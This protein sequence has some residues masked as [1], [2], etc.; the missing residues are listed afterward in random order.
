MNDIEK[1]FYHNQNRDLKKYP[2]YL[3]IY[4]KYFS[5][6]R[7][8]NIN[9][10]EIGV[11]YGG[12]L[13]MWKAYFGDNVK[14]YG[15]DHNDCSRM[16][17]EQIE[18]FIGSQS[19]RKFLK[20]FCEKIKKIDILIDDGSH[21][22]SDQITTFEELF[23]YISENGIY[24]CEDLH[25]SYRENYGGGYKNPN[26]FVEYSKK[27]IDYVNM[28]FERESESKS[29]EKIQRNQFSRTIKALHFYHILLVIEKG[30]APKE[31]SPIRTGIR[32]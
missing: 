13:Q 17:E 21:E 22:C 15:I 32:Q 4:D 18:T 26:S 3:E 16:Q 10:V 20:S 2:H 14:I 30:A 28:Y 1:Y 6:F 29:G 8:Q 19:D 9:V 31:T 7:N 27:L 25:T 12:S 23:P 5:K 24:V 11:S